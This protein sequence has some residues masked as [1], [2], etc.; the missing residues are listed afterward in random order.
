HLGAF[1]GARLPAGPPNSERWQDVFRMPPYRR[2]D[3]G[4]SKVLVSEN[5]PLS[6]RHLSLIKDMWISLEIFNLLNINNTISYFWV[7]SSYGDMFAVPN[8]LTG[9]KINLK[10]SVN[11]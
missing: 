5:N 7:S 11:F 8:Y 10:L 2:V 6:N 1:Y 4:F 3:L 9:R